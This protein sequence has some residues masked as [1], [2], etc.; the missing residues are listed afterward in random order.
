M[1]LIKYIKRIL[2]I[3]LYKPESRI[4]LLYNDISYDSNYYFLCMRC[5]KV[6]VIHTYGIDEIG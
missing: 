3:H 2:C 5:G 1:R 4:S 6:K